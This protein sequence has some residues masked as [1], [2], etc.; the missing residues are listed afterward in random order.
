MTRPDDFSGP[1]RGNLSQEWTGTP[2]YAGHPYPSPHPDPGQSYQPHQPHQSYQ[3]Y[4]S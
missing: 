1:A 3:S 2:T 4:Q